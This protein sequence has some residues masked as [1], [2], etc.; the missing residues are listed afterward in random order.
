M[1][2]K[3]SSISANKPRGTKAS[4]P[5]RAPRLVERQPWYRRLLGGIFTKP[6]SGKWVALGVIV[7]LAILLVVIAIFGR[8]GNADAATLASATA[9]VWPTTVGPVLT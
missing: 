1:A 9:V 6:G 5:G 2:D 3:Y 7:A 8:G 4:R